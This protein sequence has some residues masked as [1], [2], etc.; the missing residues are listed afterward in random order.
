[1]RAREIRQQGLATRTD[2]GPFSPFSACVCV[3]STCKQLRPK[4]KKR[5]VDS[6]KKLNKHD[7]SGLHFAPILLLIGSGFAS[8]ESGETNDLRAAPQKFALRRGPPEDAAFYCFH[9]FISF[10]KRLFYLRADYGS[11][12]NCSLV[13]FDRRRV[14]GRPFS[15]VENPSTADESLFQ[16]IF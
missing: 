13:C 8:W 1:M 12:K 11:V 7:R 10:F 9:R 2:R 3:C 4:R 14:R 16:S 15:K 5:D 6:T